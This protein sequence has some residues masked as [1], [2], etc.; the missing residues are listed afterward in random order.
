MSS[1]SVWILT[2]GLM[3]ATAVPSDP[4]RDPRFQT[5]IAEAVA[6]VV[7]Q[8][9]EAPAAVEALRQLGDG[10]R[11]AL[12]LQLALYVAAAEGTEQSMAGALIAQQLAFTQSEKLDAVLPHMMTAGPRL[13]RAFTELLATI[14]RPEG[15]DPDFRTYEERITKAKEAPPDP[16]IL[17]MFEVS[18][19]AALA[20]MERVY[21]SNAAEQRPRPR[22]VAELRVL[23]LRRGASPAWTERERDSARAAL[24]GLARDPGWW[25]RLYAA[26]VLRE[27]P[28]LATPEITSRLKSDPHP[29]VR[30][31]AK[32][33]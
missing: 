33:G 5:K 18:P 19:D 23:L 15:G 31:A 32:T 1:L 25:R 17:Y 2:L 28:E 27:H 3:L 24:D 10:E 9:E 29:L 12:L 13:R 6:S 26:A 22:S 11:E 8:D 7:R 20:S 30:R 21:G 16:L 4:P 14:D